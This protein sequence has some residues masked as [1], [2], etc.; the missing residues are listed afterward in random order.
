MIQWY[1]NLGKE[2]SNIKK[3]RK[4]YFT[5]FDFNEDYFVEIGVKNEKKKKLF[6]TPT[7]QSCTKIAATLH[8]ASNIAEILQRC[9][10][11]FCAVWEAITFSTFSTLGRHQSRNWG[12]YSM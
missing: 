10:C 9:C 2:L 1:K 8:I 4:K 3:L 11:K 7:V 6:K 5:T 12:K